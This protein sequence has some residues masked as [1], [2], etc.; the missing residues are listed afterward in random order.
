MFLL[1]EKTISDF[2]NKYYMSQNISQRLKDI[3][4]SR[5]DVKL[6]NA[7][8]ETIFELKNVEAP[9][10]W[11]DNA[12][13]IAAEK[14]F[15]KGEKKETSVV[16]MAWRIANV[17]KDWSYPK[18]F[19]DPI[20]AQQFSEI[21]VYL[22]LTQTFS[23]NSPVWFNIGKPGAKNQVSACFLNE[24]EDNMESILDLCVKEGMIY[25][26]GSGSG[27]NYSKLRGKGEKLSGGGSSSGVMSFLKAHDAIAGSIKSGGA[28]RRAAK[29]CILDVDHPDIEEFIDSKLKE[30][31]KA[32]ALIK[33]GYSSDFRD[34]DG[35]YGSV[36]YQN[37][38]HTV[39]VT[40]AFMKAA[41]N[42]EGGELFN[43][44]LVSRVDGTSVKQVSAYE[45]LRKI[46]VAAWET[47][48][49]GLVFYD[50]VNKYNTLAKD[51]TITTANPC[52]EILSLTNSVC[53]LA[54]I[55]LM[56]LLVGPE[57][58]QAFDY[59]GLANISAIVTIALDILL[60]RA[61]FPTE[62][63][64]KNAQ[65]YRQIGLGPS[66]LGGLLMAC[67]FGYDSEAGRRRTSEM[68]AVMTGAAYYTSSLMADQP[69]LGCFPGFETNRLS[70][71]DVLAKHTQSVRSQLP[72]GL[73]GMIWEKLAAKEHI[74]F[75]NSEVTC[76]APTGTIGLLM[77]CDSTGI[78]PLLTLS[79][80]KQLVGGGTIIITPK[81]VVAG[82][83]LC[84]IKN[85]ESV[86]AEADGIVV[87]KELGY[88]LPKFITALGSP[89][90]NP[91]E[92]EGHIKMLAAIQPFI[93]MGISKT[94]NMPATSTIS[95]VF[96]AFNTAHAC[97]LK[98]ITI[99]RDGC[100]SSQPYVTKREVDEKTTVV[101][102]NRDRSENHGQ[103]RR[104]PDER[105]SVTHKFSIAGHEGYIT[106]GLF[107]D[108]S[109]GEVFIT[110]SKEGSMVSGLLD[111]FAT[112]FSIALQYGASL[113]SLILKLKDHT[114]EPYGITTNPD[115]RFAKSITDY[116]A[117]YL[118][119]RFVRPNGEIKKS[120]NHNVYVG[121]EIPGKIVENPGKVGH[122]KAQSVPD[123]LS[124]PPCT[125]CGSIMVRNGS[126]Y[127]C[128]SCGITSGCS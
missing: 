13:T 8:G 47:G 61:D 10:S 107:P 102:Q 30:E 113:D 120:G 83:K 121:P 77:D 119:Q 81:C 123:T 71:I 115:I 74:A 126:C 60:D 31:N 53:N 110:I 34:P 117:R 45:L 58:S 4:L 40:D 3:R 109:V 46:A 23:F 105:Q 92:W 78:E 70:M 12:V 1:E 35:A 96:K 84:G 82:M 5:R 38:N 93:S 24:I 124:G 63:F 68:M 7:Q 116:V 52:F 27:V 101:V 85:P 33:A 17:I 97:G 15:L 69:S 56:K 89:G 25:K 127:L 125:R 98:S 9:E 32:R 112:M 2:V 21:I 14:Y 28:T 49:P 73:A 55:N 36:A 39:L 122:D 114:Y 88:N 19:E 103:R 76:C 44:D 11:S 65:R 67:G 80:T 51:G 48:D 22:V 6:S 29:L 42:T 50:T 100:K 62:E 106:T 118:E 104:L 43:F 37:A 108:G 59:I 75:R 99:Y 95:E 20:V 66:N 57:G 72:N 87:T 86:A 128:R 16:E 64:K 54:S 94:I 41:N 26:H 90:I 79:M 111:A 18:Y 91:I